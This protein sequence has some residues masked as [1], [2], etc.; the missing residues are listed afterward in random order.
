MRAGRLALE[1]L[2][3]SGTANRAITSAL[4]LAWRLEAQL[5]EAAGERGPGEAAQR[6]VAAA[7][8]LLALGRSEE[9]RAMQ[10]RP[11]AIGDE[12]LEPWPE[13]AGA[14]TLSVKTHH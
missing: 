2:G 12:P 5:G 8:A 10:A 14:G 1:Q 13:D 11:A 6:A 7:Q 3:K 9:G 4:A